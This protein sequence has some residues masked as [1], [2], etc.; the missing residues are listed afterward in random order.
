MNFFT[1]SLN[2]HG[3]DF[4]QCSVGLNRAAF[5]IQSVNTQAQSLNNIGL[6]V[7]MCHTQCGTNENKCY[8]EDILPFWPLS[9]IHTQ[10]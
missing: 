7:R 2:H 6:Y 8:H 10:T 1:M 3:L 4:N 9:S 5:L